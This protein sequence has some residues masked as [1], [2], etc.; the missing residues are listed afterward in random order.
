MTFSSPRA[1]WA[2][3]A[4][5]LCSAASRTQ[6]CSL[7]VPVSLWDSSAGVSPAEGQALPLLHLCGSSMQRLPALKQNKIKNQISLDNFEFS[8]LPLYFMLFPRP[9]PGGWEVLGKGARASAPFGRTVKAVA[10]EL[11]LP[12]SNTSQGLREGAFIHS[13][14]LYHRNSADGAFLCVLVPSLNTNPH[15]GPDCS[16]I[17][18]TV[19]AQW[20][21]F[22][23]QQR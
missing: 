9:R 19:S 5:S 1:C 4:A 13:K 8:S 18:L 6:R 11:L 7:P 15:Q 22:G 12:A 20:D 16:D 3:G 17:A 2:M 21:D 23:L 10:I 14:A